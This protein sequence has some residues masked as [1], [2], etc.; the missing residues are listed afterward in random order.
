MWVQLPFVFSQITRLTYGRTDRQT[1]LSWL[2]RVAR[3]A[4]YACSAVK[5]ERI[6]S[7]SNSNV[8]LHGDAITSS[9]QKLRLGSGSRLNTA[10]LRLGQLHQ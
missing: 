6:L 9:L 8:S 7:L 4:M 1:A 2:D 5:T 10:C 3:N